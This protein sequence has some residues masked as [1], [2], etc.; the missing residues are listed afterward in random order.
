MNLLNSDL[1]CFFLNVMYWLKDII[2]IDVSRDTLWH[3]FRLSWD[4]TALGPVK[5]VRGGTALH[6]CTWF[7]LCAPRECLTTRVWLHTKKSFHKRV[8]FWAYGAYDW[9]S[10]IWL[11][12]LECY[13]FC[14]QMEALACEEN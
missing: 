12:D 13:S 6:K 2:D 9:K 5:E 3:Q 4:C 11:S 8:Y 14:V 7:L 10:K 1:F